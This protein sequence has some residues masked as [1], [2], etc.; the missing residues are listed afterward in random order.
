MASHEKHLY[1]PLELP[2]RDKQD[3]S[4]RDGCEEVVSCKLSAGGDCP[5]KRILASGDHF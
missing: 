3:F 4:Y 2:S 1:T 5:L